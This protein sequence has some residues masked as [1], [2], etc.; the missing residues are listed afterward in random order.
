MATFGWKKDRSVKD[1]LFAEPWRFSFFQAVRL[2]ELL[3]PDA[4]SPGKS[5]EP[6]REPVRFRSSPSLAFPA[7]EI[8]QLTAASDPAEPPVMTVNFF[9]L[10]GAQGPIAIADTE[11]LLERIAAKDTG[12][13]DFLDVF[14]HRLISLFYR[15]RKAHRI[16]LTSRR[17]EQTPVAQYLFSFIGLGIAPLRNR[18]RCGDRSLLYYAGLLSQKPRSAIGLQRMLSDLFQVQIVI[19]Q[20]SGAWRHLEPAEWTHIGVTG[21]NQ[22]L[23]LTAAAGTRVWDQQGHFEMDLGPMG[24]DQFLQFLPSGRHWQAL[25]EVTGFYA[26][27]EFQFSFRLIL[28]ASEVPSSYLGKSTLGWTSWLQTKAASADDSQVR[29]RPVTNR[30]P[31]GK[32]HLP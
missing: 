6:H 3:R 8:Q 16:A 27:T 22:V 14:N 1:W 23:G 25:C 31:K 21:R 18:L 26:G 20:F 19:R 30:M 4:T 32:P 29:L 10:G 24:L 28:V 11:L 12:F 15:A 13:R 17:P 2:L 9:G 5:S 7:S